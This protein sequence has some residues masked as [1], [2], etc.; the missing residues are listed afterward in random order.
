MFKLRT[1]N[2]QSYIGRLRGIEQR[3]RRG[4]IQPAG[5]ASLVTHIRQIHGVLLQIDVVAQ[6]DQILIDVVHH[7]VI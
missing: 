7:D 6:D 3:L 4:N 2:S 5:H 1:L